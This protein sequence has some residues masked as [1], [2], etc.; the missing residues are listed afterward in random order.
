MN[1]CIYKTTGLLFLMMLILVSCNKAAPAEAPAV[2]SVPVTV[3]HIDTTAVESYIDL[4]ATTA[5]LIKNTIKANT[6]G[7]L[8][9]VKVASNDF[10]SNHQLLFALKTREA[11]VLGNTI[12]KIDPSLNFGNAIQVRATCDG[13]VNAVNVQK[14]DYVQE[15]D[16]LAVINDA[17]SFSIVLSLPYEL[18]KFVPL[19]K[20]LNVYLPDGTTI[21]TKVEKYMPSV[22]PASQTQNVILKSIKAVNIPE[23]LIVKVRIDK[24]ADTKTISLPKQAILSDETQT[25][26][27]IM[28]VVGNN[29]AVKVPVKKG[30]ESADKIEI[31]SPKLKT[32]DQILLTGNYGVGD[33][34]KIKIINK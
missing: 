31:L 4:N 34:I 9:V 33:S 7:Y 6:T 29:L 8:E 18:R 2:V 21:Q 22:D 17:N 13:F 1:K 14:G 11:K 24:T 32:S 5:Y 23:N 12:N 20:I 10:V 27:W 26:F 16:I 3:T 28:K 30:I 25:D 19:N 15:G